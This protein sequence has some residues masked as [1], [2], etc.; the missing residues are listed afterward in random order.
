MGGVLLAQNIYKQK[1][2]NLAT[3]DF[4]GKPDF[5]DTLHQKFFSYRGDSGV[6]SVTVLDISFDPTFKV[7]RGKVSE[8]YDGVIAGTLKATEGTLIDKKKIKLDSLDGLEIEYEST[9][10]PNVP[11]R[12]FKRVVF[13]NDRLYNCDF[14][15]SS[16]LATQTFLSREKFFNSF[17]VT[18][19]KKS[20]RQDTDT[21]YQTG[22]EIGYYVIGPLFIIGIIALIVYFIVR[23]SRS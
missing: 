4:P 8:V 16:S 1:L 2:S 17:T 19:D 15:T 23:K 20:L 12:R 5:H 14:W 10:N 7:K 22:Y 3:I 11:D 6:Y 9:A 18:A 13:F 21:A